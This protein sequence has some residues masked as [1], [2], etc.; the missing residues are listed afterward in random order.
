MH[1]P[2]Q[3]QRLV[4]QIARQLRV[5]ELRILD[6]IAE[7]AERTA[8][9]LGF[10]FDAAHVFVV[11]LKRLAECNQLLRYLEAEGDDPDGAGGGGEGI[12]HVGQV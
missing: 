3:P 5:R 6:D 1:H 12:A 8:K 4:C 10:G 9:T 2:L 11:A 7:G